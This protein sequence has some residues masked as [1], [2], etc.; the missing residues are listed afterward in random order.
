MIYNQGYK[1]NY[2]CKIYF[3]GKY[4]EATKLLISYGA[5]P[6]NTCFGKTIGEIIEESMPYFDISKVD[7][8]KKPRRN[9]IKDYGY[10]LAKILDKIQISSKNNSSN[11]SQNLIQFKTLL[12]RFSAT[13][14]DNFNANGMNLLQKSCNYGLEEFANLLLD[15]GADP[16]K[17][18]E[19]CGTVPVLFAG[20]YLLTQGNI[21]LTKIK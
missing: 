2:C 14:L 8:I 13:E 16:N 20:K 11:K 1:T 4:S 15:H 6:L 19:E 7:I 12:N 17:T 10:A 5:S 3:L 9:S 21:I 18:I